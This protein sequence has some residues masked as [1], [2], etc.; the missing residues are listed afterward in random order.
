MV[1]LNTPG[2]YDGEVVAWANGKIAAQRRK[3]RFRDIDALKIR[4]F[5]FD[6]YFGGALASD[7][8]PQDQRIYI[9]NLVISRGR[10][11]CND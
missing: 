4:R 6:A 2:K 1:K 7:T 11:G 10:I 9:D 8:P 5:T 3:L